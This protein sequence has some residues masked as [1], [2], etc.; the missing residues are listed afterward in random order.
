FPATIC[1]SINQE[2]VHG[3]PGRRVLMEGDL[4]S[5]DVGAVWEGYHGDSA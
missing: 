4:L 5:L 2:I 1:A 3:I